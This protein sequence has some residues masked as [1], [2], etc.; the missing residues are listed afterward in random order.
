MNIK[1]MN[2]I[3][4]VFTKIFLLLIFIFFIFHMISTCHANGKPIE[5][6]ILNHSEINFDKNLYET[7]LEKVIN[8]DRLAEFAA[9]IPDTV[10]INIYK[11][12][13]NVNVRG[14]A[15]VS[16]DFYHLVVFIDD[17]T[18]FDYIFGVFT[19]EA[20]HLVQ[21]RWACSTIHKMIDEGFA[22]WISGK[23]YLE[24]QAYH[25][26]HHA[27]AT[28][29]NNG[30]LFPLLSNPEPY[31]LD[32]FT[33]RDIIYLEWAS[34]IDFIVSEYGLKPLKTFLLLMDDDAFM[35]LRKKLRNDIGRKRDLSKMKNEIIEKAYHKA[36]NKSFEELT[37]E[38]MR[39]YSLTQAF[40]EQKTVPINNASPGAH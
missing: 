11:K 18:S 13:K 7:E 31:P 36:F 2:C 9:Y 26:Y 5:V 32:A 17:S 16:S 25:S 19:H 39:H 4:F 37:G 29:K 38:W 20:G 27:L 24:W 10:M 30:T 21:E 6:V 40:S 8:A 12:M 14:H 34:F 35:D 15:G 3:K 23:Y 1:K 28:F 22:T 33:S